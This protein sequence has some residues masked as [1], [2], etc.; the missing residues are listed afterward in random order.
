VLHSTN[1]QYRNRLLGLLDPQDRCLLSPHL[2]PVKLGLRDR[3]EQQG[4][5]IKFVYF[6]EGP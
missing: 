1:C 5:P 6:I 4:R 3:L 2:E